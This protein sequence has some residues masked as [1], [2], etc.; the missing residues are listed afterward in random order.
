MKKRI[1]TKNLAILITFVI[2]MIIVLYDLTILTINIAK[3]GGWTA[4][5]FITFLIAAGAMELS[6]EYLFDNK[7]REPQ[8]E[9]KFSK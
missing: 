4:F 3:I 5:G 8:C 7:K 9:N 2:S 6:Y 1:N